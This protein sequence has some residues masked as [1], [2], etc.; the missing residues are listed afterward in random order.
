MFPESQYK[1]RTF[2]SRVFFNMTWALVL[3]GLVAYGVAS[4]PPFVSALLSNY[5]GLLILAVLEVILVMV[6]SR[7]I[8]VM[9][10]GAAYVG[11]IAF[12]LVNGVTLSLIF[13]IYRIESIFVVFLASAGLFAVM[14]VI[15]YVTKK[16]M[17]AMGRFFLMSLIGIILV[18]LVNFFIGSETLMYVISIVS[19]IVFSGLTAYDVQRLKKMYESAAMSPE[20]VEKVAIMGA[21]S[22]YLDL[23][24]L[25]LNLLRIFGRR[26]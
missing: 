4:Y 17:S 26:R 18:S 1:E 7:R 3:T 24:N 12:S 23:I 21:L 25:F 13:L 11:L 16:D 2:F 14:G 15:G 9:S 6:L 22:L 10:I 20:L 19:V 8:M 5:S